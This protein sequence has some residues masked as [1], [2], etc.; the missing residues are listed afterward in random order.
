MNAAQVAVGGVFHD[1]LRREGV[2]PQARL[3]FQQLSAA[4]LVVQVHGAERHGG[5]HVLLL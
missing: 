4:R 2:F 5:S 1:K 3:D